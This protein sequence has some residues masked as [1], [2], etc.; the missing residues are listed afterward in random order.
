MRY[1]FVVGAPGSRW[2]GVA[3]FLSESSA[4]DTG[5]HT[6]AR[7]YFHKGLQ[8]FRHFGSYF[9]PKLEFGDWFDQLNLRS[10]T[11]A[12]LEFNRPWLDK[13]VTG[14]R[15]IKSH[16]FA[17]HLDYLRSA[18]PDCPIVLVY[19]PDQRCLDWWL[20]YGGFEITHPSYAWYRD[21]GTISQ[22]IAKQN[23]SIMHFANTLGLK[24]DL[25]DTAD[26]CDRLHIPR[27]SRHIMSYGEMDIQVAV[28]I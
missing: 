22:H 17:Y 24:F 16:M 1:C 12:E 19:R 25:Y 13:P 4:I 18:W 8:K 5:D 6:E 15:I 26:A 14:I 23:S 20:N 9:G 21:V 27:P 11:E 2:S 28:I 3:N 10:K 7:Q